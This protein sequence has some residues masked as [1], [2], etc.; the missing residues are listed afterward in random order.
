MKVEA[1]LSIQQ[2]VGAT[3]IAR[4]RFLQHRWDS[5]K[6]NT[7]ESG[8]SAEVTSNKSP[9]QALFK[10]SED[11]IFFFLPIKAFDLVLNSKY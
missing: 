6:L 9:T 11:D 7:S 1:A 5:W 8:D 10:L 2:A 3:Q 4:Q